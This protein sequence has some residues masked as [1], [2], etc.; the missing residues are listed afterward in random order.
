[1]RIWTKPEAIEQTIDALETSFVFQVLYAASFRN[2]PT[3]ALRLASLVRIPLR[4]QR[5]RL[6]AFRVTEGMGPTL[7]RVFASSRWLM[8]VVVLVR[9][10]FSTM[11]AM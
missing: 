7:W 2:G 4:R 1:M 10:T 3:P 6:P 5:G 9:S 8:L 11:A